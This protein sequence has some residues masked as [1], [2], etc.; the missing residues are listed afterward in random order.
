MDNKSRLNN[1]KRYNQIGMFIRQFVEI[2]IIVILIGFLPYIFGK[3]IWDLLELLVIPIVLA[4]IAF[5]FNRS[6][7]KAGDRIANEGQQES[8][9]QAYLDQ[10]T[11]LLLEY[12]LCNLSSDSR[13]TNDTVRNIA[14][15]RT[16]TVLRRLNGERKGLII[17]FLYQSN[18]IQKGRPHIDLSGADLSNADLSGTDLGENRDRT[19]MSYLTLSEDHLAGVNLTNANLTEAKL[20]EANLVMA[21]L[22]QANM[23]AAN[24]IF[25]DMRCTTLTGACIQD[26]NLMG[27]NLSSATGLT[28]NQLQ[29]ASSIKG[30][31]LPD[32]SKVE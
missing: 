30:V 23:T 27:S 20:S 3:T 6:E 28:Q 21:N 8:A 17:R 9:L 22:T 26:A 7:R 5:L 1:P 25:A 31:I 14:R 32:G 29:K 16:L 18:L 13:E 4:V 2:L 15:A 11:E 24:L 12:N 10:M 19:F